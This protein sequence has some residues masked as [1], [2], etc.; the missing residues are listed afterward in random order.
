MQLDEAAQMSAPAAHKKKK[1]RQ[2]EG[3]VNE[4]AALL[5]VVLVGVDGNGIDRAILSRVKATQW[6]TKSPKAKAYSRYGARA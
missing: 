1:K 4:P 6:R 3:V 5:L 2:W